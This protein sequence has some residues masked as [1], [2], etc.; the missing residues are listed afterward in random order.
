M[1]GINKLECCPELSETS[2]Q[3]SW[4]MLSTSQLL[5]NEIL[6]S[7]FE[8]LNINDILNAARVCRRWRLNSLSPCVWRKLRLSLNENGIFCQVLLHEYKSPLKF[9]QSTH[10]KQILS[11]VKKATTLRVCKSLFTQLQSQLNQIHYLDAPFHDIIDADLIKMLT[12]LP[13]LRS[14]N[15]E[16]CRYLSVN[17]IPFIST[18]S[19]ELKSINLSNTYMD[20]AALR[21]LVRNAPNII[22]LNF[23]QCPGVTDEGVLGICQYI[24]ERVQVLKM[25]ACFAVSRQGF[26]KGL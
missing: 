18:V 8:T 19:R 10:R 23:S 26:R 15:L 1:K 17:V 12:H 11:S 7:I 25:A 20:D 22:E 3:T 21:F 4:Q 5:P 2:F 13:S 9:M 16:R 24:S 14:L 6:Q